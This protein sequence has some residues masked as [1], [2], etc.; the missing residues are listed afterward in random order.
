MRNEWRV[1]PPCPASRRA[2][3]PTD[4]VVAKAIL[5]IALS[6]TPEVRPNA[7]DFGTSQPLDDDDLLGVVV[8]SVQGPGVPVPGVKALP[9]D[10]LSLDGS[11]AL[12]P[13]GVK[14]PQHGGLEK[15]LIA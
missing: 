7:N 4:D 5:D 2:S 9:A 10:V 13:R 15:C 6:S 3:D 8:L 14:W 1:L 12:V 11:S